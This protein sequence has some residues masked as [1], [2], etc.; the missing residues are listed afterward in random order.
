[1]NHAAVVKEEYALAQDIF[2]H[3]MRMNNTSCGNLRFHTS[4]TSTF[5][6]DIFL[7]ARSPMDTLYLF[8]GDLT[9]HGLPAAVAA[10]PINKIFFAMAAKG[11][12]I[13]SIVREINQTLHHLLPDNIFCAG[14]IMEMSTDGTQVKFWSGGMP[15]LMVTDPNNRL[16]DVIPS[17]HMPL[18]SQASGEF[19]NNIQILQLVPGSHLYLFTDGIIELEDKNGFHFGEDNIKQI[20]STPDCHHFEKIINTV[21][22]FTAT[23]QHD[24]ITLL[25]V[26]SKPLQWPTPNREECIRQRAE[27]IKYALPW[28]ISMR[29]SG[30]NFQRGDPASQLI[31]FL[32]SATGLDLHQDTLSMILT[33]LYS[34][35]LE[36]GLMNLDSRLKN[37]EEGF[38]QYYISRSEGI[39]K[40]CAEDQF[41]DIHIKFEPDHNNPVITIRVTDSGN[42]FDPGS[43]KNSDENDLHGR[44]QKLLHT[45]C[46]QLVYSNGGRTATATYQLLNPHS[47]N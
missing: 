25:E 1:M 38:V 15:S 30:N 17:A 8:I 32:S 41:V 4:P 29:V 26:K 47:L 27:K 21:S 3:F 24:D 33:E 45:L 46:D 44:G 31:N 13:S 9:G 20:L 28:E 36:H 2:E 35:A 23:G 12:A 39:R 40:I 6:G 43:V 42:G 16:C 34:N 5:N 18:G 37:S 19:E 11:I 22:Q 14:L 10:V 7:C